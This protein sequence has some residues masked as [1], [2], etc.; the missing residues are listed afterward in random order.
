M[1]PTQYHNIQSSLLRFCSQFRLDMAAK[2]VSL[3]TVNM[4]AHTDE[5]EWPEGDFIGVGESEILIEETYSGSCFFAL[6]TLDDTNLYRMGQ[7]MKEL[8]SRLL[9]NRSIPVY[10]TETGMQIGSIFVLQGTKIEAPMPTKTQPIQ[11]ILVN[12]ETDLRSF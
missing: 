5:S 11:P 7:L 12:Y 2:G 8:S 1:F 3:E 4:D 9:P 10:D 6:S